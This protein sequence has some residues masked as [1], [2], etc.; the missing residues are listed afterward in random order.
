M[1][2]LSPVS[3]L[4]LWISTAALG[5]DEFIGLARREAESRAQEPAPRPAKAEAGV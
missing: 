5:L 4:V 3:V 1:D 2:E